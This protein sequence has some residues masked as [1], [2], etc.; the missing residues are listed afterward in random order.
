M[1][2]LTLYTHPWCSDC[3]E[4]KKILNKSGIPYTEH[5]LNEDP[6]KEAKL[7]KLTG[8]RVVPGW[9]FR[10]N[11]LLGKIQKPKVYTGYERN[12]T[13]IN[14]LLSEMKSTQRN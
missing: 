12:R 14:T 9:V 10:K 5:N 7:K 6:G 1:Y 3:Q 2:N 11:T 13:E 4:S 8:S